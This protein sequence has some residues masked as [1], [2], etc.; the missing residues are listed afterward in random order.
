MI[1]LKQIHLTR[2]CHNS[3]VFSREICVMRCGSANR[4][5]FIGRFYCGVAGLSGGQLGPVSPDSPELVQ[6]AMWS[7]SAHLLAVPLT[8]FV[9]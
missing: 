6:N 3:H 8:V 5:T 9:V 1:A 4:P 2:F 7:F